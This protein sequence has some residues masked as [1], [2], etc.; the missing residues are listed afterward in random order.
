M[1]DTIRRSGR[2]V[3]G[4]VRT[5]GFTLL[6]LMVFSVGEIHAELRLP[7]SP[8]LQQVAYDDGSSWKAMELMTGSVEGPGGGITPVARFKADLGGPKTY[9]TLANPVSE[10]AISIARPKFRFTAEEG[11][12]R[13]VRLAQ[14][15]TMERARRTPVQVGNGPTVFHRITE[16]EVNKVSD[17]VWEVRPKKSLQP[18]EY[19]LVLDELAPVADFTVVERGY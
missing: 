14:F 17:G 7:E 18:G 11:M 4:T 2:Y 8:T 16:V 5:I 19:A 1:Q 13:R 15:E 12:A 6:C 3:P 9:F 10:L